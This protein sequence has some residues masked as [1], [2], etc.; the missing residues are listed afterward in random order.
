MKILIVNKFLY[1]KGGSETYIFKL[2]HCLKEKGND[3]QY[4][5]MDHDERCVG[6]DVNEY[7]SHIDFHSDSF[8]KKAKN[9]FKVIYSKE[10]RIKIRKVLDDF[11]PDVCHINNFNFQLTPSIILEI[12]KYEKTKNKRIKI[13]Y[14]AHDFQ[15]VCPN[16]LVFN[17][18]NNELCTKCINGRYIN[19]LKGKCIHKSKVKSLF[20]TIEAWY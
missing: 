15:L 12:R 3:V 9:V 16:H 10:A 7:V 17:P 13:I 1:P 20:G 4:F 6:N 14:T 5:G 2:G 18:N 8:F 19:C 11:N